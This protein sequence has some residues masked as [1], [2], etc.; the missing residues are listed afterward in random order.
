MFRIVI[1]KLECNIRQDFV[2]TKSMAR[3][4]NPIGW[5][6]IRQAESTLISIYREDG[7]SS[8]V[9]LICVDN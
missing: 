5:D 6:P 2:C 1:R 7:A 9:N 8:A 4:H 3:A